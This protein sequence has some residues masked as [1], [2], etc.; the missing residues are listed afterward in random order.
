MAAAI[1]T[2][3]LAI[4]AYGSLLYRPGFDYLERQPATLIGYA[5]SFSQASPD[6]R[7]TS[8]RPGRVV[9]LVERAGTSVM[10]AV[11]WVAAPALEL[12]AELDFRERAG[13]ERVRLLVSTAAGTPE[14]VTW[15]APP[16]NAYDVGRL[17]L[18]ALAEH[19]RHSVGPSGRNDE[20]VFLLEDALAELGATDPHVSGLA[21]LLRR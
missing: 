18:A 1:S 7:G 2:H 21:A 8:E 14:A 10:G 3:R 4:F 12:L 6:H 19:V 9:T 20:Y 5:R 13:Y 17:P 16:G 11:Y 15:I